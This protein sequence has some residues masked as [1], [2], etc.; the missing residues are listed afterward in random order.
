MSG[1]FDGSN[2]HGSINGGGRKIE[3]HTSG[4]SISIHPID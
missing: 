4:G 2:I 3:A 1:T